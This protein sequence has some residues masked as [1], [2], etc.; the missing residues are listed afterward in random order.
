[1]RKIVAGLFV[2][3]DGVVESP[4]R[5][6]TPYFNEEIG[7]VLGSQM[8]A[9]DTMLLG[10]VTYEEFA[11]YWA[12]KGS[13]VPFAA[14]INGIPKLVASKTLAEADWQNTTVINGDLAARL[15]ALKQ[16]PGKDIIT[17]GSPTLVA[18][19]LQARL[20]DELR[21]LVYPVMVGRG[22]RIF[23]NGLD[24]MSLELVD[25]RTL[26]NGVLSLAYVPSPS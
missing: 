20:L 22:R 25:S 8:A 14:A 23:E 12:D 15:S 9:A 1:M 2:S 3:L 10:R 4:E 11:A 13:D 17:S 18:S 5:W 26:S 6:N 7:A 24:Q 16:L 19:L 21:L